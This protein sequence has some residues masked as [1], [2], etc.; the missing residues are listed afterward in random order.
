[1]YIYK[2]MQKY[3]TI[4]KNTQKYTNNNIYIY[5]NTQKQQK[6]T[7]IFKIHK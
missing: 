3:T 1:M 2:N 7:K 5:K 6:Y 4:F